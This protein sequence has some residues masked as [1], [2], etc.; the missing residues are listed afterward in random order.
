MTTDES[1]FA[2]STAG[3]PRWLLLVGAIALLLLSWG[4][5][6]W[7]IEFEIDL[8]LPYDTSWY[9]YWGWPQDSPPAGS[10]QRDMN[11][12]L[13]SSIGGALPAVLIVGA[14]ALLLAAT[15]FRIPQFRKR[16]TS[17]LLSFAVTNFVSVLVMFLIS[18]TTTA[19]FVEGWAGWRR[20]V[21]ACLPI[22]LLL[23]LLFVLQI[24]VLPK[25][26][27]YERN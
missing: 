8:L 15:F 20:T 23:I 10:W 1:R 9:D 22:C 19:L 6:Y 27:V 12:F 25:W 7:F 16:P 5:L 11:Y 2:F 4:A 18:Y 26:L 3:L 21:I 13:E 24:Q 14:S 17:L